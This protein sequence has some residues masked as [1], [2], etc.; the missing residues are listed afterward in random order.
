MN[1]FDHLLL[2]EL[3]QRLGWAIVHSLWQGTLVTGFLALAL[4]M[5]PRRLAAARY[6]ASC[7]ALLTIFGLFVASFLWA[8]PE[9]RKTTAAGK[10]PF[11]KPGIISA[12]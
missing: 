5:V 11:P 1:V 7:L 12:L 4:W 10:V 3:A 9:V 8:P 6:A 2:T